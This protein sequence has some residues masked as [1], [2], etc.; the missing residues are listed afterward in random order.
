MSGEPGQD[1][2]NFAAPRVPLVFSVT[3]HLQVEASK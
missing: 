1:L 3:N 2:A